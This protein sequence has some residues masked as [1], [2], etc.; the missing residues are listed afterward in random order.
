VADRFSRSGGTYD[1]QAVLEYLEQL[2]IDEDEPMRMAVQ[3]QQR[4]QLP[5]IQVSP[6]DGATIALL[7]ATVGA[8]KVVEV[9]TLTGYSGLWILRALGSNG[10]LWTFESEPRAA[11]AARLVFARAGVA[12]RVDVIEGA[13]TETLP[14]IVEHGP[15]DAV[16]IDADKL[17]YPAYCEWALHNVRS[18]G[19]VLADN[20][21]LFGY[22]AGR[23]P[24]AR[25]SAADIES[26]QR[27]HQ[28]LASRCTTA[29]V[30]PSGD[31]L[32]VGVVP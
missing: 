8:R 29:M 6:S 11:A 25:A 2:Y 26:M 7:L 14:G 10:R 16:F 18:G 32:A 15:F 3:L 4:E 13:A 19:L 27:F 17:S 5:A 1:Q 22:L 9:G 30:L 24:S 23:E 28:T 12:E 31:G 21:Y 20:A